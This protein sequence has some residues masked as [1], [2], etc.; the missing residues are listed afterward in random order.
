[1]TQSGHM[2][3]Q[4]IYCDVS[5]CRYNDQHQQCCELGSIQVAP[6]QQVYSGKAADETLCASYAKRD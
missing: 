4:S 3:R 5:S 6:T 1:M 2:G